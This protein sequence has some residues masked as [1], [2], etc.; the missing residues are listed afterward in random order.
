MKRPIEPQ[1]F[2][3][4]YEVDRTTWDN[5]VIALGGS[6]FHTHAW[7][8]FLR[9]QRNGL[10]VFAR[11]VDTAGEVT[12][13]AVGSRWSPITS[14]LARIATILS[15]DAPPAVG[16]HGPMP[17]IEPL[18]SWARREGAIELR[19]GSFE[20]GGRPWHGDLRDCDERIEFLASPGDESELRRRM[21]RS[22]REGIRRAVRH[23]VEVE[24]AEEAQ[25]TLFANLYASMASRLKREKQVELG[26]IDP[27]RFGANLEGLL[28][29]Q[30]GRLYLARL[31][32]E[33]IAG[34][35]FGVAGHTATYLYNGST[36]A[37]LRVA[38][39]PLTLLRAMTEF[40]E[41]GFERIN[42]G[43]VPASARDPSSQDHGL[44]AFKS[45][46]GTEPVVCRGGRIRVHRMRLRL[47]DFARSIRARG[48]R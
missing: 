17:G 25:A 2:E 7:A 14:R 5:H 6:V 30:H 43:G 18:V 45:G 12:A 9:Q 21:R 46:L 27:E 42:L 11:W 37:A 1:R 48:M 44:F 22:G 15:F 20:G 26:S 23:G 19:L 3:A 28:A 8:M 10:P 35:F 40:S 4:A 47:L 34:C 31:D 36:D 38:A 16:D 13:I 29:S 32:G 24:R 39:T 41:E 33:Y